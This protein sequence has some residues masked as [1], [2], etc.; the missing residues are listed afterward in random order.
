MKIKGTDKRTQREFL[1]E[2]VI[3]NGG[4]S[5]W[6]GQPF[7]PDYAVTLVNALR[8]AE[9]AGSKLEEALEVIADLRP[10]FTLAETSIL[11]PL[12]LHLGRLNRNLV[13][14]G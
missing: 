8:D 2:Q 1:V 11:G 10:G 13:Q 14:Q 5:P 7:S 4:A 3:E 9:E 12:D 6:D